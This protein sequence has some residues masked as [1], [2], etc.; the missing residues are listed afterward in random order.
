M[1]RAIVRAILTLIH[2]STVD[3]IAL[4]A[5][6]AFT[7]ETARCVGTC[8]VGTTGL[9]TTFVYIGAGLT[10][11]RK[12]GLTGAE[13]VATD[14]SA[15]SLR[16]ARIFIFAFVDIGADLSITAIP[17]AA[18]TAKAAGSVV[19]HCI[20]P[21]AVSS[22]GTFIDIYTLLGV[23]SCKPGRAGFEERSCFRVIA[24]G[25]KQ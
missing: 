14:I 1:F 2:I 10:I 7:S 15:G 25:R 16:V 12:P 3:A 22:C 8:C 19:T 23:I 9:R 21:A 18:R 17:G 13:I 20:C 5:R 4:E 6:Q 24:A 11:T